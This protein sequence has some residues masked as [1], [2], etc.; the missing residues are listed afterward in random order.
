[1]IIILIFLTIASIVFFYK[2]VKHHHYSSGIWI[3]IIQQ[4]IFQAILV[5]FEFPFYLRHM[6]LMD[7]MS[8]PPHHFQL[9]VILLTF[10]LLP[11]GILYVLRAF[12]DIIHYANS[13]PN[14]LTSSQ[15][16]WTFLNISLAIFSWTQVLFQCVFISEVFCRIKFG[17]MRQC[18]HFFLLLATVNFC[19]WL[20]WTL[21]CKLV[22][23]HGRTFTI[24][25]VIEWII[26]VYSTAP[27]IM[28]YFAHATACFL[29]ISNHV[30]I[31][32]T[33]PDNPPN[34]ATRANS[35]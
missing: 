1:M 23:I 20:S 10:P 34:V 18:A 14:P 32:N 15:P 8:T 7:S 6:K 29:E 27:F 13:E 16:F 28:F 5:M 31:D 33:M 30:E 2:E 9:D 22:T 35:V 26:V 12:P 3:F 25:G 24:Y 11:L 21:E 17:S 4:L 19:I